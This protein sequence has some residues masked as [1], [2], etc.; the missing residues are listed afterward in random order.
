LINPYDFDGY[1]SLDE[2]VEKIQNGIKNFLNL[3]PDY[4]R[5]MMATQC[6]EIVENINW[7]NDNDYE[8]YFKGQKTNKKN[9]RRFLQ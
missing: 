1:L 8:P 5:E 9:R 4:H 3:N 7:I 2:L 6:S